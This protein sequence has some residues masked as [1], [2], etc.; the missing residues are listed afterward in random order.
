MNPF[1]KVAIAGIMLTAVVRGW[2]AEINVQ[3][4]VSVRGN[5]TVTS[6]I[7]SSNGGRITTLKYEG[8]IRN[9]QYNKDR[10]VCAI[11]LQPGTQINDVY[12]VASMSSGKIM[13][14]KNFNDRLLNALGK[15]SDELN[16]D[17]IYV[18]H[19]EERTFDV[20]LGAKDEPNYSLKAN[21]TLR[22]NIEIIPSSIT[23][24]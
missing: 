24:E 22:G 18:D 20:S 4:Q 15:E 17:Y 16:T 21:L 3:E 9:I 23:K 12:V 14:I 1:I 2:S 5:V 10:T 11:N 7:I 6:L 19:I 8:T 13:V